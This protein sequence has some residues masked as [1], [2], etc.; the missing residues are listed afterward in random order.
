MLQ[1]FLFP[2][3]STRGGSEE[4]SIAEDDDEEADDDDEVV[5]GLQVQADMVEKLGQTMGKNRDIKWAV[6]REVSCVFR[7]LLPLALAAR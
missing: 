1:P 2:T 7:L 4:F 5:K 3:P 6:Y